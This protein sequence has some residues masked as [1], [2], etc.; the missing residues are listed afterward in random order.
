MNIKKTL[1]ALCTIA[2][3]TSAPVQIAS[4]D[5]DVFEELHS[6]CNVPAD[7]ADSLTCEDNF[8]LVCA[9]T[10]GNAHTASAA[11]NLNVSNAEAAVALLVGFAKVGEGIGSSCNSNLPPQC[12]AAGIVS[13]YNP[14]LNRSAS[15]CAAAAPGAVST[16]LNCDG[17][18][19]VPGPGGA[20]GAQP[21]GNSLGCVTAS[22]NFAL[23]NATLNVGPLCALPLN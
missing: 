6:A 18:P 20:A 23:P 15:V 8:D 4:A 2:F 21:L 13:L 19:G 3:F 7:A 9:I 14:T 12:I 10:A 22:A 1:R 11:C 5:T 16:T 17:F